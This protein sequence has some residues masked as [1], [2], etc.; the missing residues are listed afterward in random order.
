MTGEGNRLRR[1]AFR[2]WIAVGVAALVWMGWRLLGP[3]LAILVPPV[4]LAIIVVYLLNPIVGGLERAHIHRFLGTALAYVIMLSAVAVPAVIVSPLLAEQ[5]A[6][7]SEQ[8]PEVIDGLIVDAEDW[9]RVRG[10]DADLQSPFDTE[11]LSNIDQVV[12][13]EQGGAA[14]AA[15]VGGLSGL[16]TGLVRLVLIALLGPVIAFYVLVDLP[17]LREWTVAHLPPSRR[18]EAVTVGRELSGVIGGYLRGQL[19][20]AL[21]VGTAVTTGMWLIDLPY[22][23]V[24]GIVA[25]VTN[26]VPLLGPF[27]AGVL[28]GGI[29]LFH[30]GV[31]LALLVIVVLTV[32]QQ[33]DNHLISPLVM[34]QSVQLHPLAVLMALLVGGTLYG[35]PGLLVAVPLVAAGRVLAAHAWN[36]RVAWVREAREQ[37]AAQAVAASPEAPADTMGSAPAQT[38]NGRGESAGGEAVEGGDRS[39]AEVRGR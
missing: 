6:S 5:A 30:G 19:L 12:D 3:I 29:A 11:A 7:I 16:A 14:I 4:L 2:V 39:A 10:V 32:V 13:I 36:T 18:E 23:L 24:V 21:F 28:G 15:I 17:R 31:G 33:L 8:A 27:V 34:G 25:G 22:W 1:R 35:L 37:E 9:L 20:V 26:L 38:Q